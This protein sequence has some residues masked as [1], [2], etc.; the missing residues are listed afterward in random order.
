[1][2]TQFVSSGLQK[3][4]PTP[5]VLRQRLEQQLCVQEEDGE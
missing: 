5:F 2:T 3:H 4:T 1:L